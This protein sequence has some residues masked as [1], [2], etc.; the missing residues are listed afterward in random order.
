MEIKTI[1]E[2]IEITRQYLEIPWKTRK[3]LRNKLT[4]YTHRDKT[5]GLTICNIELTELYKI[6]SENDCIYC[7]EVE[8]HKKTLDK[9]DN[10]KGHIKGNIVVAC[11][12]CN[13]E[14]GDRVSME[15]FLVFNKMLDYYNKI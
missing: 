2:K 12:R 13:T 14:R 4:H 1:A 11:I 3:W 7:G 8:L 6:F 15:R 5:Q 10:T 9:I